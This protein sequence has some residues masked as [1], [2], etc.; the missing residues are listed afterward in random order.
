MNTK[1]LFE[2]KTIWGLVIAAI[3]TVAGMFGYSVSEGFAESAQGL[4]DGGV[5]L[6]GLAIAFWGRLVATKGLVIKK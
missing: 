5:Q 3:P 1:H 4:V 2:S 6:V